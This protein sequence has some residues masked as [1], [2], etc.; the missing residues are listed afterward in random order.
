MKPHERKTEATKDVKPR[1]AIV[2]EIMILTAPKWDAKSKKF[3][4][5]MTIPEACEKV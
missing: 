1:L 2:E 5:A 3:K 4:K